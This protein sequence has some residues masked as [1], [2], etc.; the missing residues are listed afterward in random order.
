MIRTSPNTPL[1]KVRPPVTLGQ[2]IATGQDAR[3]SLLEPSTYTWHCACGWD[4]RYSL[5][6]CQKAA[7]LIWC[8]DEAGGLPFQSAM[9]SLSVQGGV[10]MPSTWQR[11]RHQRDISWSAGSADLAATLTE[12]HR[13]WSCF[14]F[15]NDC[16][17][18]P[19]GCCSLS[20][21]VLKSGIALARHGV[22]T[23]GQARCWAGKGQEI[24]GSKI[25]RDDLGDSSISSRSQK[26]VWHLVKSHV[27]S[28]GRLA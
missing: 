17:G 1:K 13:L 2:T 19:P 15:V 12:V 4:R 8:K 18:S 26:S 7:G 22:T 3:P 10:K 14:Q 16:R 28:H 27:T 21:A 5:G 23:L 25:T 20:A 24:E 6:L 11:D 9:Q